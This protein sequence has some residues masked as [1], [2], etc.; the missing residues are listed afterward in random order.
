MVP[1]LNE[2]RHLGVDIARS[3]SDQSV[4]VVTVDG[5]VKHAEGWQSEDLMETAK[6]SMA[7]AT[8]W[9][10]PGVNLHGDM[11]GM[12]AGVAPGSKRRRVYT[13]LATADND[14]ATADTRLPLCGYGAVNGGVTW[15]KSASEPRNRRSLRMA[16]AGRSCGLGRHIARAGMRSRSTSC[17]AG[18][19]A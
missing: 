1:E 18:N 12:G 4:A 19:T 9:G 14:R 7:I 10:V 2:G 3:G 13:A 16:T 5:V 17:Y 8:E 6:R 11:D 15:A